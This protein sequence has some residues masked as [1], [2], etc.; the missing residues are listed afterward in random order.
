VPTRCKMAGGEAVFQEECVH[1]PRRWSRLQLKILAWFLIPTAIILTVVALFTFYT[2]QQVTEDLALERNH[3]VTQLLAGQLAATLEEYVHQL[4]GIAAA[5]LADADSLSQQTM[6]RLFADE[7]WDFDGGV[8][9]LDVQGRVVAAEWQRAGVVGQD[10]SDREWFG[11]ARQSMQPAFSD[12]VP[13][14]PEEAEVVVIAV[15]MQDSQG[16]FSG[17]IAGM[18]HMSPGPG[19]RGSALYADIFQQ[20]RELGSDAVYLVDGNGRAIFHSNTWHIGEDMTAYGVLQQLIGS[21]TEDLH[22]QDA[23]GQE[24]VA[25]FTRVPGTPWGLVVRQN[26]QHLIRASQR[27]RPSL[28]LLL[29]LTVLVPA[30]IIAFGARRITQP[31]HRLTQAA[32][33]VAG[34]QFD[35]RI[36]VNTGDELEELAEQFNC[37][38]SQL[39]ESYASLEQRVADRTRELSTLNTIS[40]LVSRSLDLEAI[41]QDALDKILEVTST[42]MGVA[43]R[44][45]DDG[46]TLILLAHRGLSDRF[47]RH[48]ARLPLW[49]S[50]AGQAAAEA[51]PVALHLSEYPESEL[52][53]LLGQEGV[54]MAI[55]IPLVAKGKVLGAINLGSRGARDLEPEERALLAA[56]GQQTGVAV[57]NA[58]LYEQAEET[59]AAA[60]RSRLARDLHDA[61]TQTLFS[62]QLVA[63]VLPRLW[64][65]NPEEARRRLEELRQLTRGALAEMRTLL[66][67]LR[68][69]ALAEAPLADLLRQLA[70]ASTGQARV[71]VQLQVEG[72]CSPP[73]E[74]KIT[75]YRIAQEALNNVSKH[76]A[77]SQATVSL[78]CM[79]SGMRLKVADDGRGF[80]PTD[81]PADHLG[82]RIMH[83]RAA[84]IGATL[85]IRS[86]PGRGT[87]VLAAWERPAGE[88]S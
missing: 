5:G 23:Q 78:H 48:V 50:A 68:P 83:E 53:D 61:V 40:A 32:Q 38:S 66:L 12:I 34:G 62:A 11:Q 73:A 81:V 36:A 45:A 51:T 84:A 87:E 88:H 3:E 71:P 43:Y 30:V 59:A 57:E 22:T 41:L 65:R 69:G 67:E 4:R 44:V 52:K 27:Y 28:I 74:V 54:H 46:E 37:M 17:I 25:S 1:K 77:A 21:S 31:I 79:E 39:R 19:A 13:D 49:A 72:D 63:D 47:V 64:E 86:Q 29:A 42:D 9:V 85:A 26:W 82:L 10:W 75:L 56:I 6:L 60:E 16:A 18:F 35:Q 80:D 24:I 2:Y 58:R 14:G 8:L 70:D 76:A 20:L 7:L 33:Q 55:S 15:P